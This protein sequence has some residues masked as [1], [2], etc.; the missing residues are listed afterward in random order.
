MCEI[1]AG[2]LELRSFREK[3]SLFS[4]TWGIEANAIGV[5]EL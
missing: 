3:H 4:R 2:F 5:R 1:D